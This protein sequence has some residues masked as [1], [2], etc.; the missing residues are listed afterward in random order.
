[1]HINF[2][3]NF[4]PL[5]LEYSEGVPLGHNGLRT[6]HCHCSG[7][8]RCCGSGLIPGLGTSTCCGCSKKKKKKPKE[9]FGD[10]GGRCGHCYLDVLVCVWWG[11]AGCL[12]GLLSNKK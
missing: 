1:M 6:L 10:R 7:S 4:S 3:S 9:Y 5:T 11:M 12:R 2:Y 8:G